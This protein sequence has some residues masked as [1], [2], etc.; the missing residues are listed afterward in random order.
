MAGGGAA[1]LN[2][3]LAQETL[4]DAVETSCSPLR[5]AWLGPIPMEG[6][7]VPGVAREILSGLT[8][9]GHQVDCYLAGNP[10]P[11][12]RQLRDTPNLRAVW[13]GSRWRWGRW[14]SRDQLSAFLTGNASRV[15]GM[16]RLGRNLV[17]EH[18]SRPYDVLYQFSTTEIVGFRRQLGKLP[19]LVLHPE[20]HAAGE[21]RWM[22]KEAALAARCMPAYRRLPARAVMTLRTHVQRRDIKF[23]AAVICI[24]NC[25]RTHLI[26]DYDVAEERTTVIAN[27]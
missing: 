23:A 9:L 14:Y 25:F 22:R 18:C 3:H 17:R 16:R 20:T 8:R 2:R 6:G 10:Q 13:A 27:P 1:P 4:L 12:P 19:P 24:S 21:L 15:L 5:V 7:G 11:L 26:R